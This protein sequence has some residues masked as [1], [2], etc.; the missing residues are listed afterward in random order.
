M[1]G[2]AR[3][4]DLMAEQL[5]VHNVYFLLKD[6]SAAARHKLID[7]C[8]RHLPGHP[9]IVLFACGE[10]AGELAREVNDRDWDVGLHI[11]FG[12]QAA[13]DHYQQTAAHLAFIAENRDNW[14]RVRVFDTVAG[15]S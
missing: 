6:R 15:R 7:A 11:V 10:L 2:S 13:H 5:L 8:R 4:D 1:R 9:G 14:D 3:E 12:D